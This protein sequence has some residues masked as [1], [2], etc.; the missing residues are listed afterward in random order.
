MKTTS[1][2]GPR[3]CCA[4]NLVTGQLHQLTPR[5]PIEI[6]PDSNLSLNRNRKR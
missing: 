6:I 5:K 3:V 1:T 4:V 2:K